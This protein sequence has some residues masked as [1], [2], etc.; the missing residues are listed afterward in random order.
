MSS[1]GA[2]LLS[3]ACG[4][5]ALHVGRNKS[6]LLDD[7]CEGVLKILHRIFY[8]DVDCIVCLDGGERRYC[9]E[10]CTNCASLWTLLITD[11]RSVQRIGNTRVML[12]GWMKDSEHSIPRDCHSEGLRPHS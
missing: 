10:Y 9:I 5:G 1:C 2:K 6:L 7:V 12:L 3:V 8:G 4:R 11:G